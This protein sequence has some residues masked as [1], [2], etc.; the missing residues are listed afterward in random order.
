MSSHTVIH[1]YLMEAF[2][3]WLETQLRVRGWQP[4]ELARKANLGA[5]TLSRILSGTRRPGPE[6][7]VAIAAVLGY[8]AEDVFRRAGLLPPAGP[9]AE[10]SKMASYLFEQ[11]PELSQDAALS[12]LRGLAGYRPGIMPQMTV[13]EVRASYDH[14]R[15]GELP[16]AE[17]SLFQAIFKLLWQFSS[18]EEKMWAVRW[19]T[20]A[21]REVH[22]VDDQEREPALEDSE[23][24]R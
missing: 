15:V 18:P 1:S 11:I 19:F 21:A 17:R 8:P 2:T 7:C 22:T 5:G 10:R 24:D 16:E 20:Q 9:A 6:V 14:V 13:S 4:A 3:D 12:M 23:D